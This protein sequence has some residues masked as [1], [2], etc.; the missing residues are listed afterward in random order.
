MGSSNIL[1]RRGAVVAIV[2][3]LGAVLLAGPASAADAGGIEGRVV[4]AT[5]GERVGG[6]DVTLHL[7]SDQTELGTAGTTTSADGSFSFPYPASGV[8]SFELSAVYRGSE[9]RTRSYSAAHPPA[10]VSVKVYEPT[11]DASK[12]HLES[13]IVWV[14]REGTGAAVQHSLTWN[15]AGDQA[16]VGTGQDPKDRVVVQVPLAPGASEFQFL[17]LFLTSPGRVQGSS[18]VD[19]APL[20]PGATNATIRYSTPTLDS[21]DLPITLPTRTLRV[22]VPRDVDVRA[23]GLTPVGQTTQQGVQYSIYVATDLSVG[24]RIQLGLSGLT[25]G[26]GGGGVSSVLVIVAGTLI[27]LALGAFVVWRLGRVARPGRRES[28]PARRSPSRV[29]R[30]AATTRRRAGSRRRPRAR[31]AVAS[32]RGRREGRPGEDEEDIDLLIDEIAALDLSFE[33][34]LLDETRYRAL[35]TAAKR[36]LVRSRDVRAG[37]VR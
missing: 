32:G 27:V 19:G 18:F 6:V 34:G 24:D 13:W 7:F 29:G 8:T 23:P 30:G 12:V 2:A 17:D 5:T 25:Q 3:A 36:R 28:L 9:Y 31:A 14:D 26:G 22:F 15:N 20:P 11:S 16:Y 33:R 1:A 10:S 35:R 4:N 21:L 37:G